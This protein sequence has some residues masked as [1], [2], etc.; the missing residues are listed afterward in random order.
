MTGRVSA[1]IFS[2]TLLMG[3]L[4]I[5]GPWTTNVR[6]QSVLNGFLVDDTPTGGC[7]PATADFDLYALKLPEDGSSSMDWTYSIDGLSSGGTF[8]AGNAYQVEARRFTVPEVFGDRF[9]L[10]ATAAP[11]ASGLG[12][13]VALD[14]TTWLEPYLGSTTLQVVGETIST[15]IPAHAGTGLVLPGDVR[16]IEVDW[17]EGPVEYPRPAGDD[18]QVVFGA[19]I[20]HRPTFY[21]AG[22]LCGFGGNEEL[23]EAPERGV[24]VGYNIYAREGEE[25]PDYWW[26]GDWIAYVP[27][28]LDGM[29]PPPDDD[30]GTSNRD[31]DSQ[32]FNGNEHVFF[33]HED[34]ATARPV[35]PVRGGLPGGG[36]GRNPNPPQ[37]GVETLEVPA[38]W[39]AIQ[40]VVLGELFDFDETTPIAGVPLGFDPVMHHGGLDLTN[41]GI[42][43]FFSP[44]AAQANAPGLGLAH[45][46]APL[47]SAAVY[48]PGREERRTGRVRSPERRPFV[49]GR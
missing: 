31:L 49:L 5:A 44:Q 46:G 1:R 19:L 32:P 41:D 37:V 12:H 6:A 2:T 40:P 11:E 17:G 4:L 30:T 34:G 25:R 42:A 28:S 23:F 3:W 18:V 29:T 8:T 27:L 13:R 36:P 47:T 24:I 33:R 45:D 39:Y 16:P 7:E 9:F 35:L 22:S 21:D 15:V 26:E 48:F 14:S 38:R 10:I 20:D 43:D